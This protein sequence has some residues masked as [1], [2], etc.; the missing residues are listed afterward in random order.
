MFPVGAEVCNTSGTDLTDVSASFVWDSANPYINLDTGQPS[1]HQIGTL[2]AGDCTATYFTVSVDK[3]AAAWD[4]TRAY[5]IEASATGASGQTPAGR[6][7]Y[8]EK[9]V[10]QNRNTT[11]AISGPGGCNIDF[12]V[13]DPPPTNLVLGNTYTYKLYAKTATAYEQLESFLTFPGSL[14][15]VE[16][17]VSEYEIPAGA[18]VDSPYA[19]ACGWDADPASADYMTCTG[20]IPPEFSPGG[21]AGGNV[22]VTYTVTTIGT[23]TGSMTSLIYDFSG[24][25]YHYN[26][27]FGSTTVNVDDQQGYPLDVTKSGNGTGTVSSDVPGIDCGSDC[28]EEYQEDTLVTLTAVADPGSTFVGWSGSGCSGTGTCVVTMDQARS[29]NAEFVISKAKLEITKIADNPVVQSGENVTFTL[30]VKNYGPGASEN[31]VVSDSVPQ[32]LTVNSADS[33]C[34]VNVQLVECVAGTLAAGETRTYRIYTTADP[35]LPVDSPNDQ[36]DISKVEQQITLQAGETTVAQITC[37]P[38]GIMSDASVRTDHVDQG[39]GDLDS[40]EVHRLHS[41]SESSY[42]TEVTNH[43]TGQAQVKL[44]AVCI[45]KKTT[46]GHDLSVGSLISETFQLDQGTHTVG[47][48]CGPGTTPIAPG[49]DVSGSRSWLLASAPDGANGRKFTLKIDQDGAIAT[50]SMRCI[51]NLTSGG[52]QLEFTP[53]SKQIV[54]GPGAVASEQLTCPVGYKG[55]VA[56]WEYEDGL[57][58]LGN[59]PQPITRVFKIWN[60]TGDPLDATLHLLCLRLR[61]GSGTPPT[62]FVN[63]AHVTSS[64]PQEPGAVLSDEATVTV[65]GSPPPPPVNA[66]PPANAPAGPAEPTIYGA[67]L[68]GRALLLKLNTGGVTGK[69]TVKSP[70]KFRLG[71]KSVR[72]NR[73]LG[74]GSFSGRSGKSRIRVRLNRIGVKAIRSGKLKR[75]RVTVKTTAGRKTAILRARR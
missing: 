44:F 62:V 59:D 12:T 49:F 50:V 58:P 20:P 31:V 63:T 40:V 13:C 24:S 32:G 36:L 30:T 48:A 4:T 7:L 35:V 53:I 5:H 74:R 26:S 55:V 16:K 70:K 46:E 3:D 61:T 10:A 75:V 19:D 60:P 21:K 22:V 51:S 64:T 23:G 52:G 25:S 68:S 37:G 67:S 1:T 29:V 54:V 71:K 38:G 28:T 65:V 18:T 39:T 8:V 72:R 27:D 43:A 33:P 47:L 66:Q 34:T 2:L 41:I 6:Q 15:R 14:F 17:A 57:I 11:E 73:A 69:V 56:G 9:L 42:E 45:G